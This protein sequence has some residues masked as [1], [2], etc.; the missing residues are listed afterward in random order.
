MTPWGHDANSNF[1]LGVNRGVPVLWCRALV[2]GNEGGISVEVM[3]S[4][5]EITMWPRCE[6]RCVP[7]GTPLA[8]W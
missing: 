4:G 8:S 2:T 7:C 6:C 1:H 5:G 3:I